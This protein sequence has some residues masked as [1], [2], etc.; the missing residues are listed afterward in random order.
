MTVSQPFATP[1]RLQIWWNDLTTHLSTIAADSSEGSVRDRILL[2]ISYISDKSSEVQ[3]PH[4]LLNHH[5]VRLI[6]TKNI[7]PS[8]F[9]MPAKYERTTPSIKEVT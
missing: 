7:V 1:A 8:V 4:S 3:P 9:G 6:H 5:Q 2:N